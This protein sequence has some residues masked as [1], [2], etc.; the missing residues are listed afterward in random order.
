[1]E[2]QTHNPPITLKFGHDFLIKINYEIIM[3]LAQKLGLYLLN[4]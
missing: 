3:D 4:Y 1:M 2:L